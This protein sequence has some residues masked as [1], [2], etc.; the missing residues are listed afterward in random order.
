MPDLGLE[1]VYPS[2]TLAE[3]DRRGRRSPDPPPSG[4]RRRAAAGGLVA[5]LLLGVREALEPEPERPAVV[6]VDPR[7]IPDGEGISLLLVPGDPAA[8]RVWVR[9]AR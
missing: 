9:P 2:A 6:E 8:S 1:E 4:L 7:S 5:G 3:I